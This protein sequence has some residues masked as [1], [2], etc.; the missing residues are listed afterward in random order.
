MNAQS[1]SFTFFNELKP[2]TVNT[3]DPAFPDGFLENKQQE[4]QNAAS[5]GGEYSNQGN[6]LNNVIES[7]VDETWDQNVGTYPS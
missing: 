6:S 1:F 7:N 3:S 4:K 5:I 2:F